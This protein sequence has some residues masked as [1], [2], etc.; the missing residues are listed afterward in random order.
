LQPYRKKSEAFQRLLKFS[1][2][3]F[4]PF[5]VLAWIGTVVYKLALQA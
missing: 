5:K 4:G 1:S 2:R 3:F